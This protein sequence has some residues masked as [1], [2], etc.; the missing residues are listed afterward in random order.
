MRRGGKGNGFDNSTT[1]LERREEVNTRDEF[2]LVFV[3]AKLLKGLYRH[4]K[5]LILST[6]VLTAQVS[7][8]FR[9]IGIVFPE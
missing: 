1:S 2:I 9:K 7:E 5:T 6:L 4:L 3:I 8:G